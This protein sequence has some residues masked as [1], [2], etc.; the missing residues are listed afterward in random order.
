MSGSVARVSIGVP[1]Y[2]GE[3]YVGPMIQSLLRQTM[4]DFVITICDNASTDRTGEICREF[5]SRDPRVRYHRNDTNIGATP[6]FN[7]V[8]DIA[9]TLGQYFKWAPADD[10]YEPTYLEKCVAA[11]DADPGV[12]VA[13]PRTRLIDG[14]GRSIEIDPDPPRLSTMSNRVTTRF[15]AA[16]D[17]VWCFPELGVHRP[18]VLRQCVQQSYYGSDK[19][20]L[21]ELCLRGRF[22]RVDDKLFLKRWHDDSSMSETQDSK[23]RSMW[24]MG[25]TKAPLI[26]S[27]LK[28][29]FGY[30]RAVWRVKLPLLDKL[31]CWSLSLGM[32]LRRDKWKKLVVP[33]PYNYLGITGS[34]SN[35]AQV[36]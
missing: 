13:F 25:L 12:V 30:Q 2:N 33:G 31:S 9:H 24:A 11:L 8:Q 19:V 27:Q 29:Y 35:R 18:Q 23:K 6:N 14:E 26:P 1:V 4:G 34:R 36:I 22:C 17:E 32:A 10:L 28:M 7:R 15:A 20:M 21:A 5:A 3:P 16:L